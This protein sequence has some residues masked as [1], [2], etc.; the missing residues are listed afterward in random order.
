M[1]SHDLLPAFS[2][3]PL[4]RGEKREIRY[5]L[6]QAYRRMD[7]FRSPEVAFLVDE[8]MNEHHVPGLSITVMQNDEI[9]SLGYGKTVLE[10]TTVYTADTL[11]DI[12]SSSG[13]LTVAC[14]RL[15]V[16]DNEN[17]PEMQYDAIMSTLLPGDF[18]IPGTG[19]TEGVTLEDILSYRS[20]MPS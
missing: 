5:E 2:L 17:Y 4:C 15:L 10:L 9:A 12:V 19:Y 16:N 18:V 7:S 11:F 6:S 1:Q 20:G 8:L 13:F 14:V 3:T